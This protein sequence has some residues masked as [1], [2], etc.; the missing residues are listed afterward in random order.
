VI[1]QLTYVERGAQALG[2][3]LYQPDGPGP[4]PAVVSVHGGA[5]TS[6]DRMGNA[7]LDVALYEAGI[8]VLAVD[9]RMPP[10]AGYP[11]AVRDV[12]AAIRWLKANA[13][14]L[15][16]EP[17]LVGA[18]G[19]SSGGQTVLLCALRPHDERFAD[20]AAPGE[21]D[22]AVAFAAVGWPIADPPARYRMAQ[23]KG[24]AKLVAAHEAYFGDEATMLAASPQRIVAEGEAT[25]LPPLLILQGTADANVTP[26]MAA[27][28]SDAYERAGGSAVLH[29]FDGQPHSF[30]KDGDPLAAA[31]AKRLIAAFILAHGAHRDRVPS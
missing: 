30:I 29:V 6:G 10:D 5:W 26:D 7:E 19:S 2:A 11:A 13:A 23:A 12:N 9:F 18:V 8:V 31:E 1:S 15:H 4:F 16:T 25:A 22:G 27:N 17:S 14:T 28:F 24:N 21:A 3:T 20:P